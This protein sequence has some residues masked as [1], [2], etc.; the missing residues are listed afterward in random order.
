MPPVFAMIALITLTLSFNASAA[1]GNS[2]KRKKKNRDRDHPNYQRY[3]D[4][5]EY[6][7]GRSIRIA[8]IL[9][10]SIG[11]GVGGSLLLTGVLWNSC[12]GATT[13]QRP[14]CQRNARTAMAVGGLATVGSLGSGIPMI[15]IGNKKMSNAR[16]RINTEFPTD[17]EIAGVKKETGNNLFGGYSLAV[18]VLNVEF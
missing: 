13:E 7:S 4:D 17:A 2:E 10:A 9:L 6:G 18:R 12:W 3:L 16:R 8:G 1:D 14:K 5:E 11:G 15:I